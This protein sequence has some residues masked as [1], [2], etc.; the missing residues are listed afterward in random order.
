MVGDQPL[1]DAA[2]PWMRRRVAVMARPATPRANTQSSETRSPALSGR[3]LAAARIACAAIASLAIALFVIG[4]PALYLRFRTL[5]QYDDPARRALVVAN[6]AH[7]GLSVEHYAAYLITL[8]VILAIVCF[9]TAVSIVVRRSDQPMALFVALLLTLLGATFSGAIEALGEQNS[10]FARLNNLLSSVSLMAVFLLF[11]VFPDGRF[12]PRWTRW[13]ALL[14]VVCLG[15]SALAPGSPLE[16]A[17]WPGA[18]YALFLSGMLVTGMVAQVYRYRRVASAAQ[19]QQTKWVVL[20][21]AVALGVYVAAGL[22]PVAWPAARTG[23]LAHLIATGTVIGAMLLIPL[24]FGVA[25]LRHHLWDIDVVINRALVYTLLT[26]LLVGVY[27][28]SVVVLQRLL[29]PLTGQDSD[30]AI[31]ISTLVIAALFQPVRRRVQAG[32]DRHFYRRK[33]DAARTLGAFS[34][35]L[36]DEV[37]LDKLTY[38]LVGVVQETMQPTSLSVWIRPSTAR[39]RRTHDTSA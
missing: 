31:I 37:E 32:I 19:R 26:G 38:E 27:V 35:R 11:Y 29:Q 13:P 2:R 15:P 22:V 25:I 39:W 36:R 17:R 21:V 9:A 6:L 5:T 10:T 8:G 34:V 24:S 28:G 1:L 16:P 18:A 20:G 12:V 7:L 3:A 30:L 23:T 4:Q 33:Y 14:A